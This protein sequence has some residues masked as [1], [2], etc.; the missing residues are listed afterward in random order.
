MTKQCG[1]RMRILYLSLNATLRGPFPKIDPF[2]ITELQNSG[3]QVNKLVWGRHSDNENLTQKLVGR[4]VDIVHAVF[5]LIRDEYEILYIVTTLD[6]NALSRDIPL[7]LATYG[8][9]VKKVLMLHGSETE[10]LGNQGHVLYKL[11]TRVLILLSDA[12]LLLSSEEVQILEQFEPRGRYYQVNNPFVSQG[13]ATISPLTRA[14]RKNDSRPILLFVGRLIKAKGIFDLV[15]AMP[16]IMDQA[17]CQLLIAGDGPEKDRLKSLIG[18]AKLERS[19]SLLGYIDSERLSSYYRSSSIFIL[20]TYFGEGFPTVIAEAMS[21]SLPIITTPIR[22]ALDH[23][24]HGINAFFVQPRSPQ[25]IAE[26]VVHLLRNRELRSRMGYANHRKVQ[27]FRPERV[28]AR[29]IQI[30]HELLGEDVASLSS[31]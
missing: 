28:V 7:L 22:G 21:F 9:S 10:R 6:K 15:N 3:H 23:L 29:Y 30:F 19:V 13:D 17:D 2:L 25:A 26:V 8:F 24:K 11:L 27:E 12:V 14:S 20:P 1:C 4:L 16:I 5:A 31:C 18:K